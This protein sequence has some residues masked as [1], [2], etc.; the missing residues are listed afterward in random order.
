MLKAIVFDF[1]GVIVDSEPL[2][3]QAFLMVTKSIGFDFDYEKYL[4]D[5]IGFDDRDAF[6]VML[7]MVGYD[8][9]RTTKI[10]ELCEQKEKAFRA[11]VA[12]SGAPVLPGVLELI[13]EARAAMPIAIGSGATQ[14]DIALM[15][16]KLDRT[17]AFE[18]IVAAD[19]VARSKPH[20]QTYSFAV[21]RLA[22]NH[23][24]LDLKPGECLAIED[25]AAGTRAAKEAGLAVLGLTTTGPADTLHEADRVIESLDGINL[26]QLHEW[27]DDGVADQ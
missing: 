17:D 5:F 27:F 3:F 19:D 21:Q 11:V 8:D 7:D 18:T 13:D 12:M 25:T 6:R 23:P 9:D 16:E 2:H 26:Q 10:A 22:D 4:A 1:D 24:E 15:L 20:P 14:S